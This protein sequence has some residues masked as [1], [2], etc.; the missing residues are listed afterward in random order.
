[1]KKFLIFLLIIV[2]GVGG[3]FGYKMYFTSG[4]KINPIHAIPGDAAYILEMDDPFEAWETISSSAA[5][6]HLKNNSYFEYLSNYT[7]SL[8]EVINSTKALSKFVASRPMLLSGHPV[9]GE[10]EFF[11]VVDLKQ[12][13]QLLGL[14]NV[15]I[16][17][18]EDLYKVSVRDYHGYEIL[19]LYD[20]EYRETLYLSIHENLLIGSYRHNL[21]E[22]SLDQLQEPVLGR[23]LNYIEVQ[24]LVGYKGLFRLYIQYPV[25]MKYM[26]PAFED[27]PFLDVIKS[28]FTFSG[29][30][31]EMDDS[32]IQME[33]YSNLRD[34]IPNFFNLFNHTGT[35]NIDLAK[36]ASARTAT[37]MHFGFESGE[38]FYEQIEKIIDADE[39]LK[40]D[41]TSNR[42]KLEKFLDISLKEDFISWM[43]DELAIVN[44][45]TSK[46]RDDYAIIIKAKDGEDALAGL[47]HIS[48]QIRKKTPVKFRKVEYKGYPIQFLS[49]KGFF[50]IFFGKLF[51]KLEKPYYAVI[52]DYVIFSNHPGTL[53]GIIDDYE[54]GSV[55]E[56]EESFKEFES[57]MESESSVL[58]YINTNYIVKNIEAHLSDDLK[59][60]IAEN[61]DYIDC[62][63]VSGFQLYAEDGMYKNKLVIHYKDLKNAQAWNEFLKSADVGTDS[64]DMDTTA[65]PVDSL[66]HLADNIYKTEEL[67]DLNEILPDDLEA[68]MHQEFYETG[69][70]RF[71]VPLKNGM[72]HGTYI[73]YNLEGNIIR[74]GK[75]KNDEMSGVW[76]MYDKNGNVVEKIRY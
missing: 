13:S 18:F 3:Y 60:T 12:T 24:E 33:G 34:S 61:R 68:E 42:E 36:I 35:G 51:S 28:E 56:N 59:K 71:E 52:D 17:V 9:K 44:N 23:D 14:K 53:K 21:V 38:A 70:L 54:K 19:E 26:Q 1:M 29:F 55:L 64:L 39:E 4:K 31:F 47:G 49:I 76:K 73:E 75:Y 46:N 41:F 58:L 67:I 74:K 20:E 48:E 16:P 15:M 32:K 22:A 8:N 11:F 43:D 72:K 37:L 25:F 45:I 27:L 2:V 69:E 66:T 65:T 57:G 62:F 40:E 63:P 5:W 30:D 7:D 50:K 6:N 10:L